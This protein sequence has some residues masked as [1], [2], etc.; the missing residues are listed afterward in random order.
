[1]M[2]EAVFKCN[3]SSTLVCN[4]NYSSRLPPGWYKENA[5]FDLMFK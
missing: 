2:Y 3:K 4:P 1:M 5:V